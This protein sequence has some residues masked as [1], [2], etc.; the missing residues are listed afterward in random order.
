MLDLQKTVIEV[1]K[2]DE[3]F[4]SQEWDLLKNL[5]REN[6]EKLDE[7]LI[8]L[9]LDNDKLRGVFFIKIK[10]CLVFDSSKFIRFINNKE[11]LPDSY[12]SFK[13]K[14]G[15]TNSKWDLIND[16]NDIVLSFPYKDCILA[17]GQDQEDVKR[18]EVFYNEILGSDDID[19]LL[20]E[21]TFTNFKRIS[22]DW[23]NKLESFKR[24]NDGIIKDSLI[25]KGNNLL[26]L[27]SLESN[28]AWKLD[29]IYI[30]PPYNTWWNGDTFEY[31]NRFKHS[32]WLTFMKNR[33]D[34]AKK[35]LKKD[36]AMIVAID[37]AEQ[38][39]LWVLL[40]EVFP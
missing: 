15:L 26:T 29:L 17:W 4:V 13:N 8:S 9:L 37:K 21:K 32:S 7:N 27:H 34:I 24:D 2:K 18:D 14:I 33:L 28:F 40:D 12:T 19:R 16:N 25:I 23:E 6:T 22:K 31:N 11:F 5:I 39:Y 1:L 35:L 38:V 36:G 10:D 3:R 30:D 20:D